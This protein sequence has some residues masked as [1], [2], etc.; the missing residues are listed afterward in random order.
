MI[1]K[2]VGLSA[3][4]I[5]GKGKKRK[6]KTPLQVYVLLLKQGNG[7][8]SKSA[9][10]PTRLCRALFTYYSMVVPT[11]LSCALIL[12]NSPTYDSY[13][14]SFLKHKFIMQRHI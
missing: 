4:L 12:Q 5:C 7:G 8:A 14:I 11:L 2:K 1:G 9:T 10:S 6:K 13:L 3:G